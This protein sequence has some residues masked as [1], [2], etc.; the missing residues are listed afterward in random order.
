MTPSL[1][2]NCAWFLRWAL[3]SLSLHG[4]QW[5]S[6]H[7]TATS[8]RNSHTMQSITTTLISLPLLESYCSGKQ[9]NLTPWGSFE[10]TRE[11]ACLEMLLPSPLGHMHYFHTDSRQLFGVRMPESSV[12]WDATA[13]TE[14][15][16]G[17]S[18]LQAKA[19]LDQTQ[20]SSVKV[21]RLP[22]KINK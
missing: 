13:D 4:W 17:E 16:G 2:K 11:S 8:A 12:R 10:L 9:G 19:R 7:L 22:K 1:E 20:G 3:C 14:Y 6:V 18:G 15:L 5:L 21:Q